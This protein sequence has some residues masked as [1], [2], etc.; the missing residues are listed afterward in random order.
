MRNGSC[1]LLSCNFLVEFRRRD[2]C[3]GGIRHIVGFSESKYLLRSKKVR[4]LDLA[5][6]FPADASS[7]PRANEG[8][9]SSALPWPMAYRPWALAELT[10]RRPFVDTGRL[11]VIRRKLTSDRVTIDYGEAFLLF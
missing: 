11:V 2:M 6:L 4:A 10:R 7:T 9:T 1:F 5:R 8:P 3:S